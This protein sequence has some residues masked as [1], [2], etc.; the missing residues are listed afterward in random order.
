MKKFLLVW[1]VLLLASVPAFPASNRLIEWP[2]SSRYWR[3]MVNVNQYIQNYVKMRP[4]WFSQDRLVTDLTVIRI[5]PGGRD[6]AVQEYTQ[7]RRFLESRRI[8][9]GTYVS[10]RAA[11]PESKE[12][13]YPIGRV[14]LERMPPNVQYVGSLPEEQRAKLID[15]TDAPSR[16]AIQ[17]AIRQVW[18]SSPAPVRFVDNL[19]PHYKG[20]PWE[21]TC[22]HIQELRKLGESMGSRVIF[23]IPIHVGELSDRETRELIAAVGSGGIA[24]EM[25]WLPYIRASK[26]ATQ[27]AEKRYRELLDSGMAIVMIP[28]KTPEDMLTDWVRTWKKPKDHLYLAEPFFK[29]PGVNVYISK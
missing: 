15:V 27:L 23:N 11:S 10:G 18:E 3:A 13:R 14:S 16:H 5:P 2:D 9:V 20:P 29:A 6:A 22:T 24:L 25:P 7:V 8:Y 28:V 17:D 21:A 1:A 4:S 26:Q 12:H 19:P